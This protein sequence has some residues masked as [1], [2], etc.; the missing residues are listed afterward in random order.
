LKNLNQEQSGFTLV[1]LMIVLAIVGL[2][3]TIAIP[4]FRRFQSKSRQKEAHLLLAGI[5]TAELSNQGQWASFSSC[6]SQLGYVPEAARRFYAVGF[7]NTAATSVNCSDT[8]G[9]VACNSLTI[10]GAASGACNATNTLFQDPTPSADTNYSA[11][12]KVGGSI[13]TVDATLL[14]AATIGKTTFNV[15]ATG[16]ISDD[17]V[18][19]YWAISDAKVLTNPTSGL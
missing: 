2:L 3:A 10:I 7:E 8:L 4:N 14:T 11:T 6:L 1:E 17:P 15:V 13:L 19:D 5:Y 18:V 16:S 12:V 9:P